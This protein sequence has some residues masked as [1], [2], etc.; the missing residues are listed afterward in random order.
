MIKLPQQID[1]VS[2]LNGLSLTTSLAG[3]VEAYF[4]LE[5]AR[6][7][8]FIN[9]KDTFHTAFCEVVN[10]YLHVDD[11]LLSFGGVASV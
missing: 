3:L 5:L 11:I 7:G 4:Q 8:D 2:N 9:E 6:S 10:K 1:P